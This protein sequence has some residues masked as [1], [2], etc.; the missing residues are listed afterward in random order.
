MMQVRDLRKVPLEELTESEINSR[1]H[2]IADTITEQRKEIGK[3]IIMTAV[4]K[5]QLAKLRKS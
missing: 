2:L 1:L 4:L 5:A 3:N